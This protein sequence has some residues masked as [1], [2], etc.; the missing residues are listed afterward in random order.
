MGKL[1]IRFRDRAEK[2]NKCSEASQ[3]EGVTSCQE[4]G[5]SHSSG[6]VR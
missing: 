2:K 1:V 5:L 4:V 6:E 3:Q